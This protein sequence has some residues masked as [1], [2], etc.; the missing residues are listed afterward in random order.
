MKCLSNEMRS[1]FHR[2]EAYLTVAKPISS[3][4]S[5][6]NRG[7]EKFSRTELHHIII[8]PINVSFFLAN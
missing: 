3:G 6:F 1:L 2:G 5:L 4:L 7:G 8:N